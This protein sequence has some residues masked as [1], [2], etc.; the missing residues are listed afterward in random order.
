MPRAESLIRELAA[1][2][3]NRDTSF[4]TAVRP[5]VEK[6]LD[7]ATPAIARVSLLEMLA[8]TFERDVQIRRDVAA[9][10]TAW[11]ELIQLLRD[12]LG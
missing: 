5:L 9:A 10:R 7:G 2:H 11:A 3:G 6:I 4:L 12:Q 8:E 1:R